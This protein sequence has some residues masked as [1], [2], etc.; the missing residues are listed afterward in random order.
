MTL[1]PRRLRSRLALAM[2]GTSIATLAAATLTLVPPLQHRLERDQLDELRQVARTARLGIAELPASA[3][4]AQA[5]RVR[6]VARGLRK[7]AGGEVALLGPTG[8]VLADTDPDDGTAAGTRGLPRRDDVR[9]GV[10]GDEAIVRAGARARGGAHVTLVIRKPLAD[11]RAAAATV[12]GALPL[13]AVIGLLTGGVLAALASGSVLR[14]M[15]R[16]RDDARALHDEGLGRAVAV[17]G[18]RDEVG[19]VAGALEDMRRRLLREEAGRQEFLQVASHELRTP[20][21]TLQANLE[22]LVEEA[23]GDARRRADGALRQT[24][25]LVTLASDL[26]DLGRIDGGVRPALQAVELGELL[27]R[28]REELGVDFAIRTPGPV[29]AL[30]DSATVLRIAGILVDNARVHGRGAITATLAREGEEAVLAV[31][32]EGP[33]LP[34]AERERLFERF[35]RGREA[36]GRPGSGL[37]LA[38][39]RGFAEAMG[40]RLLAPGGAR[41]ELRLRAWAD[42]PAATGAGAILPA[43]PE[44]LGTSQAA[45]TASSPTITDATNAAV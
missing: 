25:R 8:R 6:L 20:L 44:R 15:R 22:L 27:A 30:A 19:E 21:A 31:C 26:L 7:R 39:A 42:Y 10:R 9:E 14:R 23:H 41:L 5:T 17:D 4:R 24:H 45:S 35:V 40:G 28:L 1:R 29:H 37:G 43:A 3:L 32:D 36:Q 38:I 33:G 16:L 34:D 2:V 12:R 13:A 11:T 18:V